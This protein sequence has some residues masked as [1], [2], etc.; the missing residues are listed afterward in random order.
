MAAGS[1]RGHLRPLIP[2][3][4]EDGDLGG[5][6]PA[7]GESRRGADP[8]KDPR[9]PVV[10]GALGLM[11]GGAAGNLVDRL[12]HAPGVGHGEVVDFP[13]LDWWPTF[14]LA[15]TAGSRDGR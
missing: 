12:F 1:S 14:N 5:G 15:D 9:P 2:E 13:Y 3:A 4:E 8:A 10:A 11:A 6:V 7:R